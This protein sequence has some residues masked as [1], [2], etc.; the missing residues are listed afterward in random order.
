MTHPKAPRDNKTDESGWNSIINM[1]ETLRAR[2]WLVKMT[3][4]IMQQGC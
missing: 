1:I 2:N 3:D 4:I